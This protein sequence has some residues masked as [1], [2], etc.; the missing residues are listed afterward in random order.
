[1]PSQLHLLETQ[2]ARSGNAPLDVLVRITKLRMYHDTPFRSFLA[3]LVAQ[4]SRW[5]TLKLELLLN[6]FPHA[7]FAALASTAGALPLLEELVFCGDGPIYTI[8]SDW[9]PMP[10]ETIKG[11]AFFKD[12]PALRRVSVGEYVSRGLDIDISLPWGQLT[13]YKGSYKGSFHDFVTDVAGAENLVECDFT[14]TYYGPYDDR[15]YTVPHLRHLA[16]TDPGFLHLLAAPAL[17]SLHIS[18]F[19]DKA[20]ARHERLG[21]VRG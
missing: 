2:L 19:R 10:E 5:R 11:I 6:Y 16:L 12:A 21:V 9:D 7:V 17:R 18:N 4:S 3:K 14:T 13:T 20:D 1:M 8:A 15:V